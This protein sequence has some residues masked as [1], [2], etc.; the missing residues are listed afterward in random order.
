MTAPTLTD[1]DAGVTMR[2]NLVNAGGVF[3]DTN[4]TFTDLDNNYNGSVLTISGLLP[5]DRLSVH[6]AGTAA[7][8]IGLSG[9][10]VTYGGVAIGTLSGGDGKALS[11]TFTAAATAPAIDALIE[12]LTYADVSDEPTATRTLVFDLTDAAGGRLNAPDTTFA[13]PKGIFPAAGNDPSPVV[14]D[15]DADGDLDFVIGYLDG[16]IQTIRNDGDTSTDV[17]G[18]EADPFARFAGQNWTVPTFADIDG[19]G[20]MDAVI[21]TASGVLRVLRNDRA[22]GFVELTGAD[23][24][25]GA[26]NVGFASAPAF[27][28][29]DKDG[30]LDAVVGT[31]DGDL[32]AYRND[33]IVNGKL[34]FTPLTGSSNPFAGM[35]VGASSRP[36]FFDLDGDGDKDAVIGAEDGVFQVAR[37]NGDGTFTLLDDNPFAGLV[38]G[39]GSVAFFDNDGDGDLDAFLGLS[40]GNLAYAENTTVKG[41]TTITV[42]V[43]AEPDA[44]D[45]T[46]RADKL[47][48]TDG[49]DMLRGFDGRDTLDGGKGAD[50]L[51]G[52]ADS[53]IY[54][55]D[56]AG[57]V[58]IETA[59]GGDDDH[60]K[61]RV[62]YT[63]AAGAAVEELSAFAPRGK[64]GID[65]AGNKFAQI[66]TGN[67]GANELDGRGGNDKLV[68][69]AGADTL[70]GGAGKD[71]LTGGAG[72]D[73]YVVDSARDVIVEG[74]GAGKADSVLAS[75]SFALAA[76]DDIEQLAASPAAAKK[77]IDLTGND[78]GQTITGNAGANELDGRGGSDVLKGG[79]G[80]DS[81]VFTTALVASNVDTIVDFAADDTIRL[82][83]AVFKGLGKGTLGAAAFTANTT[84]RAADTSD[85]IIYEKDTGNL[86]Y[87]PDGTGAIGAVLFAKLQPNLSLA[88]T[89]FV[90]F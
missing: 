85:R 67:A 52:G 87:D 43:T 25:L 8:Q 57:D 18:T 76:D 37:N 73:V 35:D 24:P 59:A 74:K 39:N 46:G 3:L 5:E 56:N 44:I 45:G 86:Y 9:N 77:P 11:I 38:G 62:S 90:V 72:D 12:N 40:D 42:T 58:V 83:D 6:N 63:L 27:V 64:T 55:V 4:V 78:L 16:R 75:A 7:G 84:G 30:D 49:P 29:L 19:D 51:I 69:L 1:L 81:F 60:V 53:D 82:D 33:G 68:G 41:S 17:T 2:E 10:T 36:S 31:E 71:T 65:L 50:T 26:V 66:I 80:K 20:D 13:I 89:D 54:V 88:N 70:D 22:A 79:A 14:A 34:T 15:I 48:A 21:G 47:T 61:A 28:D 23:N 32:L